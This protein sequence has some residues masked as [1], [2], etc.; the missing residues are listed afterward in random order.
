MKANIQFAVAILST[1]KKNKTNKELKMCCVRLSEI[2][3]H[4][5]LLNVTLHFKCS[6]FYLFPLLCK[7]HWLF[8]GRKLHDY[9]SK[10]QRVS[11]E[12]YIHVALHLQPLF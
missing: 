10:T 2:V 12:A 1:L 8:I 5:S 7:V 11:R 4:K 3:S 6:I 9:L